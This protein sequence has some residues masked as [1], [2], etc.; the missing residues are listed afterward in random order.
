MILMKRKV[1]P[2][3][4]QTIDGRFSIQIFAYKNCTERG[5]YSRLGYLKLFCRTFSGN[6]CFLLL[7]ISAKLMSGY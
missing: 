1:L 5:I 2:P 7:M 6:Q 4:P 3:Y